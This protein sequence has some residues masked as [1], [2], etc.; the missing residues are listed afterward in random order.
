MVEK[1]LGVCY[2][3][4]RLRMHQKG[5]SEETNTI[6]ARFLPKHRKA[7]PIGTSSSLRLSCRSRCSTVG[8]ILVWSLSCFYALSPASYLPRNTHRNATSWPSVSSPCYIRGFLALSHTAPR[9]SSP[10]LS[11]S[12]FTPT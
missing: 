7:F 6:V 10:L 1:E 5:N 9:V 8:F 11:H 2:E 3:V 4:C 12:E